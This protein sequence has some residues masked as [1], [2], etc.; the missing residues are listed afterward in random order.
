[1]NSHAYNQFIAQIFGATAMEMG[2]M[3]LAVLLLLV[4]FI[5]IR[6]HFF[7]FDSEV[8]PNVQQIRLPGT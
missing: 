5:T 2:A 7:N 4:V 3:V 1:M 8:G 6:D